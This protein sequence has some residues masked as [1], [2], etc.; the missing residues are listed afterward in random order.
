MFGCRTLREESAAFV[1]IITET[2][3]CCCDGDIGL[4]GAIGVATNFGAAPEA[5]TAVLDFAVITTRVILG[6]VS[7]IICFVRCSS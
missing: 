2:M 7:V 6:V 3:I 4:G 5:A 1:M